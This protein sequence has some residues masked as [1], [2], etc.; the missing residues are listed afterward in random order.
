M[1]LVGKTVQVVRIYPDIHWLYKL[2][3]VG[4]IGTVK[5]SY[6]P[7]LYKVDFN[8]G[9]RMISFSENQLQEIP[10][11]S[12][13]H[14]PPY[15]LHLES[16]SNG[17]PCP[18]CGWCEGDGVKYCFTDSLMGRVMHQNT[19]PW[20]F[21][22]PAVQAAWQA[23]DNRR[24]LYVN[25]PLEPGIHDFKKVNMIAWD[26]DYD[27]TRK[28][29]LNGVFLLRK[30]EKLFGARDDMAKELWE[31]NDAIY[32]E[33]MY[34]IQPLHNPTCQG[35]MNEI[36]DHSGFLECDECGIQVHMEQYGVR[37]PRLWGSFWEKEERK[38][39]KPKKVNQN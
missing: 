29:E 38:K 7:G 16:M 35:L 28:N 30:T 39:R 10:S 18:I 22:L 27:H 1:S 31:D 25:Q 8:D 20:R 34:E 26:A 12:V 17:G 3:L 2:C 33:F 19:N 4:H 9:K 13:I 24:Y 15:Q 5:S 36:P 21:T 14:K 23:W 11:L 6:S 32:S 37:N